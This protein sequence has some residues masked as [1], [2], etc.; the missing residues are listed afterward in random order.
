MGHV[1]KALGS[2]L[3]AAGDK[4]RAEGNKLWA[5]GVLEVYGNVTIEWKSSTHCVVDGTN[6]YTEEMR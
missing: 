1:L 6:E 5:A 4:L 3:W 2:K